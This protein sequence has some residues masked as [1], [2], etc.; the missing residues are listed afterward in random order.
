MKWG[1]LIAVPTHA[2]A[3]AP[4]STR[5]VRPLK[6]SGRKT[7]SDNPPTRRKSRTG[8]MI[9]GARDAAGADSPAM[10]VVDYS[11][12][13]SVTRIAPLLADCP[14]WFW[15]WVGFR[16]RTSETLA[17]EIDRSAMTPFCRIL[18]T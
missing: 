5:S 4:I 11:G 8:E 13:R 6:S 12:M 18:F 16:Y 3:P 1:M 15:D 10:D 14:N 9:E 2:C 7:M 17:A